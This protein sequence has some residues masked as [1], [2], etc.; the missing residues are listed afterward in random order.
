MKSIWNQNPGRPHALA[1]RDVLA[2]KFPNI[3]GL[4]KLWDKKHHEDAYDLNK[5]KIKDPLRDNLFVSIDNRITAGKVHFELILK[6][7]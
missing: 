2:E 1:L 7:F 6:G 3:F 4:G 5:E